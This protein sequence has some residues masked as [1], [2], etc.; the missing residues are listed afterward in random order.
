M[1]CTFC[2]LTSTEFAAHH[3]G[4]KGLLRT[5]A[6]MD[7][8]HFFENYLVHGQTDKAAN[9]MGPLAVGK[10]SKADTIAIQ[11]ET[12]LCPS[13]HHILL[14][15]QSSIHLPTQLHLYAI[16]PTMYFRPSSYLAYL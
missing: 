1:L 11:C 15:T 6:G 10:L 8:Q 4:G 13:V 2:S 14:F 9:W 5:A 12:V 16:G 7:M 3:P